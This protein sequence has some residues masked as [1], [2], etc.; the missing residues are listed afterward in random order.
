MTIRLDIQAKAEDVLKSEA[1]FFRASPT[2]VAKAI[3]DKVVTGG[4]V[5]DVL[6]GVDVESYQQRQQGK[7][8]RYKFQGKT[9]SV[10]SVARET[11]ISQT[12]LYGRL[13]R[14]WTLDKAASTPV[15]PIGRPYN[16]EAGR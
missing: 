16:A 5:R 9:R 2:A 3:I 1:K 15:M 6:Q 14:G 4:L 11:G 7:R 12:V 10:A 8:R 13:A